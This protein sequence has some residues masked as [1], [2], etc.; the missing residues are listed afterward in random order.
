MSIANGL[1]TSKMVRHPISMGI[2]V[3]ALILG[4][5][6]FNPS[7]EGDGGGTADAYLIQGENKFR[8][9]DYSG[10]ME[11]F[12]K[13]IQ[14]DSSSSLAYYG[15]AKSAMRNWQVNASIILTEVTDAQNE[16]GI[17]FLGA[18]DSKLTRYLQAT[19]KVRKALSSMTMRD[20]LTQWH[21]YL[22]D[23]DSKAAKKDALF[24]KRKAFMTDYLAKGKQG[25]PGY[26]PESKF[27]LSDRALP[28]Q[29]IV[30]D[31]GFVEL[32]YALVHLRDL[33]QNDTIDSRDDLIKKLNFSSEGGFKVENLEDIAADLQDPETQKNINNL[34]Q[35][36]SQGLSSAGAVI[37]LLSPM[38]GGNTGDSLSNQQLTDQVSQNV[39]SVISTLGDAVTFYQFGDGKDNDGDGCRDEEILDG[40]DNDGDG[41]TDED[42]RTVLLDKLDNDKNGQTDPLDADEMIGSDFILGYTK[43]TSF[44]KGSKYSDRETRILVQKDSLA[45][46]TT[47]TSGQRVLLQQAKTLVGGCW[48]NY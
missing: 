31:F 24:A 34:I 6:V 1:R 45:N 37:D 39:D 44:V 19:S 46:A 48:N 16:G 38:A 35:N 28:Y 30:A 18:E 8:D 21:S 10:A 5:N 36:V 29:K 42:S 47:L 17:P 7:G 26:Y 32:L 27:P 23:P 12:E 43:A 3:S 4:C 22:K 9:K 13:A 11:A 20:T 15:Y 14:Q 40:K 2:L 33:D 41:F 25:I